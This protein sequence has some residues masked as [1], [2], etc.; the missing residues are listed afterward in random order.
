MTGCVI[1]GVPHEARG[2]RVVGRHV[3]YLRLLGRTEAGITARERAVYRAGRALAPVPLLDATAADLLDWREGLSRLAPGTIRTEVT[4]VRCFLNWAVSDG[5]ATSNPAARIPVPPKRRMVPRPI[6]EPD[7]A[8]AIG[9]APERLRLWIV[10]ASYCGLRA[11]EVSFLRRENVRETAVPPVLIVSAD[12]TKGERTERV[13]PLCEFVVDEIRAAGLPP[14][15]YCFRRRDGKAG[16]NRP[17]LISHEVAEYFHKL[18][19]AATLHSCRH[20]AGTQLYRAS[21]GDLLMVRDVLGHADVST[22]QGYAAYDRQSAVDA[23][24]ALPAP[25]RLRLVRL[26]EGNHR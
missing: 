7:L 22:T 1:C 17:S 18:G 6:S 9:H 5:S 2:C 8:T 25:P 16:P 20:R 13:I 23:V 4:H 10:L 14:S 24:N 15:G 19:I 11:R 3:A 12:S 26:Q 21:R